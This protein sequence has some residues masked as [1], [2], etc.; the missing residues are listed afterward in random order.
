[1]TTTSGVQVIAPQTLDTKRAFPLH[2]A[3]LVETSA[4]TGKTF[5]IAGLYLR[6][7]GR[8]TAAPQGEADWQTTRHQEELTVD[9]ILVVTFTEAATAELRDRIDNSR[10]MMPGL[11]LL[12]GKV[13]TQWLLLCYKP[14]MIML[15]LR[16]LLSMLKDKWMRPLYTIH[17]F[18]R[19]CWPKMPLVW[20]R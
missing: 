17:G 15:V 10:S 8:S 2:G 7:L 9:Q 14:L 3:R 1:M 19:E 5:T 11:R 20:I 16:K 13:T 4:G 18:C 12:A 6:L